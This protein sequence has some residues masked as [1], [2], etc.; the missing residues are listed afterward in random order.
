MYIIQLLIFIGSFIQSHSAMLDPNFLQ[1]GLCF[2][3][4]NQMYLLIKG[5]RL[6]LDP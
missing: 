5:Y 3:G 6:E 2:I 4:V 1:L